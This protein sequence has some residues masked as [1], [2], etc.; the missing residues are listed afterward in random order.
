MSTSRVL[1][2]VMLVS[3][4]S[5]CDPAATSRRG[6]APVRRWNLEKRGARITE[7]VVER[8]VEERDQ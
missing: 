8:L 3:L 4:V 2:A 6:P 1:L 7:G 5:G